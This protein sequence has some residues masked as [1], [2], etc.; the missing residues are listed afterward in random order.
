MRRSVERR[1]RMVTICGCELN[2][3]QSKRK[4]WQGGRSL[5]VKAGTFFEPANNV[6]RE[7]DLSTGPESQRCLSGLVDRPVLYTGIGIDH[8]I[9]RSREHQVRRMPLYI[10][11]PLFKIYCRGMFCRGGRLSKSQGTGG[12]IYL[13]PL[14]H[15]PDT[16]LHGV[17]NETFLSR[18][19][20]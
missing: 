18:G 16:H 9:W 20:Y 19:L 15:I 14:L 3:E 5:G 13:Y 10:L 11:Y 2:E 6:S 7:T 1:R 12:V 17:D 4:R 8:G